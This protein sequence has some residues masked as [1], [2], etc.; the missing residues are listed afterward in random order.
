MISRSRVIVEIR[1]GELEQC[2]RLVA[3]RA[4]A[5]APGARAADRR[6]DV[7]QLFW[8]EYAAHA[9]AL[10]ERAHVVHAAQMEARANPRQLQSFSCR[11][12]ATAR[13][14]QLWR[15]P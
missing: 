5:T 8:A 10:R 2:G 11:G 14:F 1:V 13:L 12:L 4:Q 7:E 6:G 3:Q 9:R 15:G